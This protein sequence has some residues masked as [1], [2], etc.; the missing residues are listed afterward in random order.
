SWD[1]TITNPDEQTHTLVAGLTVVGAIDH[2][3][4]SNSPQ[5]IKPGAVSGRLTISAQ[6]FNNQPI[7]ALSDLTLSLT[8]TSETG[9]FSESRTDWDPVASVVLPSGESS[10]QVY[11]QDCTEGTY[12]LT[13]AETPDGGLGDAT[14]EITIDVDAP[15]RY[16]F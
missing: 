2:L 11:Y 9:T 5:T 12:T 8:T 7:T 10:V 4:F 3:V 6:D 14:Q 1:V 13:A 16:T 15:W